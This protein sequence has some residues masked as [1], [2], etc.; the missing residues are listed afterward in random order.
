MIN[1]INLF[2]SLFNTGSAI[3]S[4]TSEVDEIVAAHKEDTSA[5]VQNTS[6][7]SSNL[8]LSSR[9][10]K[11]SSL[12]NEFFGQGGLNFDDVDSLK[13]R[14]YQLGL[15]SKEEYANLTHTELSD[16]E[17]AASKDVSSQNIA[18]F[19][20]NFLERL[21][22][23]DVKAVTNA[24]NDEEPEEESETLTALKSALSQAKTILIDVEEAKK[25]PEFKESL[26]SSLSLL[27]EVINTNAF[28][29]MPLDDKVGLSKFYQALEI[30]DKISPQRL[31]N[32]KVNRYMQVAF[33]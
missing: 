15:I 22:A 5:S 11:I 29:I 14:V 10:Q 16:E 28:E 8:Y 2:N 7:N 20:G 26:T 19:I 6:S 3:P 18:S 13:E 30:V 12:S 27:K 9:S 33:E 4:N 23:I 24:D 17:L 25:S 1:N 32:D 21:D 31:T